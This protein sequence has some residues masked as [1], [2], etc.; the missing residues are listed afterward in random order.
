MAIVVDLSPILVRGAVA[1]VWLYEGLWCKLLRRERRQVEI[2]GA[3]P[4]FSPRLSAQLLLVLGA[5]EVGIGAWAITGAAPRACALVQT[6][7]LVG[8]NASGVRWARHLIQDPGGM[9][10]K[11]AAFLVLAWIA[12]GLSPA[13]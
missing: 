9:L 1:A 10:V 8:M 2:V 5:V 3:V 13:S 4:G 6:L 11:N 12:A 7:L